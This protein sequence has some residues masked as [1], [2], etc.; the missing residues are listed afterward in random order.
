MSLETLC[1]AWSR[2]FR[3]EHLL[4]LDLRASYPVGSQLTWEKSYGCICGG[5]VVEHGSG[6]IKVLN[7]R[8]GKEYWITPY[9]ILKA[10]GKI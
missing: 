5:K 3:A 8:T 10:A 6:R 1:S 4:D 7:S 9:A 2:H